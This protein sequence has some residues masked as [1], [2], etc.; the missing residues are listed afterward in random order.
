M[1]NCC[2]RATR[3]SGRTGRRLKECRQRKRGSDKGIATKKRRRQRRLLLILLSGWRGG[4]VRKRQRK[5]KIKSKSKREKSRGRR[6]GRG[7]GRSET[8]VPVRRRKYG[9]SY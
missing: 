3:T 8:A 7:G 9:A 1:R 4:A 5:S 2:I 6:R